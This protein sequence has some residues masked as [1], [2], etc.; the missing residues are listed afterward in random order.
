MGIADSQKGREGKVTKN[1]NQEDIA[2]R[3]AKCLASL[4]GAIERAG[5][6]SESILGKLETYSALKLVE[7]LGCNGIHFAFTP[8]PR[9][10]QE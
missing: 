7:I 3:I 8:P 6:S 5:G 2:A 9:E 1:Y 4:A 10:E